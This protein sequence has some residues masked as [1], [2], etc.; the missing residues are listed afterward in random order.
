ML[1]SG[2]ENR[3]RMTSL[4]GRDPRRLQAYTKS[5]ACAYD[6]PWITDTGRA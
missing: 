1:W 5:P 3:T 2:Y 6:C 4:E